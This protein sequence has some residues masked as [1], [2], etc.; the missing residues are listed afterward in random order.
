MMYMSNIID[1]DMYHVRVDI[2]ERRIHR[3]E[4]HGMHRMMRKS[5]KQN[6][7]H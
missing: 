7:D 1:G 5:N 3:I 2:Y 6:K 4:R